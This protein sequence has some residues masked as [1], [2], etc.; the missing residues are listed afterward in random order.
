V[1]GGGR[2]HEKTGCPVLLNTSF[3]VRGEPIVSSWS[4]AVRCFVRTEIDTL[5]LGDF[6]MDRAGIPTN[7]FTMRKVIPPPVKSVGEFLYTFF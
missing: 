3:N 6:V 4:D 1:Y 7:W 2:F 5:V